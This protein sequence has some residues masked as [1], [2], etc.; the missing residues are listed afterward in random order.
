MPRQALASLS[1]FLQEK[2]FDRKN[3][4]AI[5]IMISSGVAVG[6]AAIFLY[7]HVKRGDKPLKEEAVW[8]LEKLHDDLRE[9]FDVEFGFETGEFPYHLEIINKR[10]T[11]L[12]SNFVLGLIKSKLNK[13]IEATQE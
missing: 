10:G 5:T 3:R 12:S 13:V 4:R 7:L 1:S 6:G 8:L 9:R 2:L 11:K